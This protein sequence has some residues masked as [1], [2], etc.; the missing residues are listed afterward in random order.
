MP[1]KIRPD[2]WDRLFAPNARRRGGPLRALVN[3]L[4]A[5]LLVAL[6]GAG[7]VFALN[8]REQRVAQSYATATAF[9]PTA[10][11]ARAATAQV[12]QGA[13]AT[14]V[15]AL[16]GTAIAK[17]PTATP[18]GILTATVGNGGNVREAPVSGR[19]LDQVHAGEIVQL[20]GKNQDGNWFKISYGRNGKTVTGWVSKTLLTID[21]AV[22][23]QVPVGQ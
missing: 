13:T 19:P 3:I 7:T 10:A 2:D 20:L 5:V 1:S 8:F 12:K 16:T 6:L 17:L 4:L 18:E 15:A 9:A 21:P 14:I 11:A 22:E 23:Q